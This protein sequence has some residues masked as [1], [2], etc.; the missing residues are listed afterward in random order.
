MDEEQWDGILDLGFLIDEVDFQRVKAIDSDG[1]R[2]LRHHV[3]LLLSGPP[4]VPV[5]PVGS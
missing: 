1:G 4:V 2:E 5:F 3:Q